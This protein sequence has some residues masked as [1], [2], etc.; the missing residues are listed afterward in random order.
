MEVLEPA[1]LSQRQKPKFDATQTE[2]SGQPVYAP[3]GQSAKS[4]LNKSIRDAGWGMFQQYVTYKA[5]EAG[6]I[7]LLVN[8]AYT[9]Q[10]CS[11]CGAVKAKDLAER[12]HSCPCGVELDR[13]VNAAVNILRRGIGH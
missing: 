12:W 1:N 8:P 5:A 4:G 10:T 13:D 9:S 6:R 11:G 2:A 3:N 7:V